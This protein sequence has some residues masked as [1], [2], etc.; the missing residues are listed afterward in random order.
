MN[1][2]CYY[3][4]ISHLHNPHIT[5]NSLQPFGTQPFSNYE[6]VIHHYSVKSES[7][8]GQYNFASPAL[9]VYCSGSNQGLIDSFGEEDHAA[10]NYRKAT[11]VRV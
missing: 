5:P 9:H 11:C 6:T 8:P 7:R 4:L 2:T 3:K 1:F 10:S